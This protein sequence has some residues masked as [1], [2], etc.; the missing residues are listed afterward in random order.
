MKTDLYKFEKPG[1]LLYAVQELKKS[2]PNLAIL[3]LS[4]GL[5]LSVGVEN[6]CTF[7]LKINN[8]L[9]SFGATLF[10]CSDTSDSVSL[11]D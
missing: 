11:D 6:S 3:P 4:D 1:D 5:T 7:D 2:H 8:I 9:T 10:D